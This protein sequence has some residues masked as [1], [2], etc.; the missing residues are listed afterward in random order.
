M[1]AANPTLSASGRGGGVSR[2]LRG[3]LQG[4]VPLYDVKH[5]MGHKSLEMVQRYAH[6]APDYQERAIGVLNRFGHNLGTV[7]V[8]GCALPRENPYGIKP[9]PTGAAVAQG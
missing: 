5:L 9:S 4:G 1:P 3:H 6:L 2:R 8:D 7:D